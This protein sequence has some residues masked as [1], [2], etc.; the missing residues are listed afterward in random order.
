MEPV[1]A[2]FLRGLVPSEKWHKKR[3]RSPPPKGRQKGIKKGP[4]CPLQSLPK[5][6]PEGA[7]GQT[8]LYCGVDISSAMCLTVSIVSGTR[9]FSVREWYISPIA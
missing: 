9:P 6:T 3:P 1:S 8:S 5:E 7:T 2:L 4:E